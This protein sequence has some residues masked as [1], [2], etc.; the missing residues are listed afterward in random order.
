[1]LNKA[2]RAW[3]LVSFHTLAS[4]FMVVEQKKKEDVLPFPEKEN[5]N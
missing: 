2:E 3:P 4:S 5:K 1:V